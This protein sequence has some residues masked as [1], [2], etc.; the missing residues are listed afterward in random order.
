MTDTFQENP[1]PEL[2]SGD[3]SDASEPFR[4]FGEWMAD[5]E[6]REVNDPNAMAL[7]T[8]D[9]DGLPDVRM[10]LLKGLD[11]RGFV[12]YTNF[13]SAKGRQIL[14]SRKAA[15]VFHWKS[16]RRQIRVRGPVEIVSDAE[17]DAYF[18]SRA[19][20]S[21]IGAWASKQSRPLESRFAL[22]KAVAEYG[23]RHA[24]GEVPRPAH[25][26]GFRILPTHME[27]WHDRPF[28]LHDRIAFHRAT[29][30]ADWGKERLYP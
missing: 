27:F 30:D 16:L 12:F 13:E 28:R 15:L 19:R 9:E 11:P 24:I 25:W 2:M 10:V 21:R 7:A 20:G 4:L 6:A 22:E 18:A 3:F 5:A 23:L 29:P 26:S 8:V 1:P 14:A 17:A